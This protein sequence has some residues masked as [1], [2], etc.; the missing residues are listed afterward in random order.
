MAKNKA[1]ASAQKAYQKGKN[2]RAVKA[3]KPKKKKEKKIQEETRAVKSAKPKTP[4]TDVSSQYKEYKKSSFAPKTTVTKP[5]VSNSAQKAFTAGQ[6]ARE[7]QKKRG[8][9]NTSVPKT[10]GKISDSFKTSK[11]DLQKAYKKGSQTTT[12]G[13]KQKKTT[14]K[15]GKSKLE[16]VNALTRSE[17]S[18][19]ETASRYG[20]KMGNQLL[21]GGKRTGQKDIREKVG[22]KTAESA[23]KSKAATGVMQGMSKADIFSNSVGTYNKQAK[24]AIKKTKE[25]AAYNVGY[26]LGMAADMGMGGVASRGASAAELTGKGAAKLLGKEAAKQLPKKAA[27]EAAEEVAKVSGKQGAK[28]FAKNRAGEL[29]AET[30]TNVLD[31]AKMSLDENGKLDKKEFKKWLA[32]NTGLTAG[33]GG[34]MEGIGAAATKKLSNKTI[35]LLGK[36]QAGTISKDEAQQLAKNLDKLKNKSGNNALSGDIASKGIN[37]VNAMA[38][39]ARI[40]R[41]KAKSQARAPRVEAEFKQRKIDRQKRFEARNTEDKYYNQLA[42]ENPNGTFTDATKTN[43]PN[44]DVRPKG[45]KQ[46]PKARREVRNKVHTALTKNTVDAKAYSKAEKA[47]ID[48]TIDTISN[49]IHNGDLEG[50]R[51]LSKKLARKYGQV[52]EV[53]LSSNPELW[54]EVKNAQKHMRSITIHTP[55]GN[56]R[57]KDIEEH[58]IDGYDWKNL[59]IRKSTHGKNRSYGVDEIW[60]E[61]SENYPAVFSKE[62]TDNT[63]RLRRLAEVS[64]MK[65]KDTASGFRLG[66]DE[67]QANQDDVWQ[68]IYAAAEENAGKFEGGEA[69]SF[70]AI[71]EDEAKRLKNL[72]AVNKRLDDINAKKE[73]AT[74]EE[75][76]RL[77][78]EESVVK[79]AK[80]NLENPKTGGYAA[81]DE[82]MPM[83]KG[84]AS[85][86]QI[87]RIIKQSEG[88]LDGVYSA[89]K[90][91]DEDGVIRSETRG[92][93]GVARTWQQVREA[94]VDNF[95][96]LED[97]AKQLPDEA[98]NKML[99][100]INELRR[101]QKT[102]RA[103]VAE[104]GRA[105]YSKYG[106]TKRG[107]ETE[108]KREDFEWYCF[109]KHELDRKKAGNN[110][111]DLSRDEIYKQLKELENKYPK[112][113][114][115]GVVT[116]SQIA[117]FQKETTKYFD[118]LLEREVDA[119]ITSAE[120][121]ANFR[122]MY[123]NYVPTYKPQEFEQML[124]RNTKDEI[125]VGRGLKAATGGSHELVPL[126]NQMQ[127]KTNVVLKRTELNRTLNLLCQA[128]G[129]TL[130]ELDEAIPFF[131][132]MANEDKPKALLDTQVF[133]QAREGKHIA[134]MYH[135]GEK[136]EISI[137]P[138]VYDAIRRWSGED[139]K[140]LTLSRIVDNKVTRGVNTQFKKWITDYNIFFGLKNFKR[141]TATALYYTKDIK[142]F[143]KNFPKA[144]AVCTLPDKLLTK[145]MKMYKEAL[146]VYKE[147]GGIISQFIARDTATTTFFDT[148]GKFNP[149]KWAE[150]FNSTLETIPR[151][152]EFLSAIESNVAKQ[153]EKKIADMS[154]EELSEAFSA[155]LKDKNVIADS[156]YRA[157]D[158]TLNFDRSGWLGSMLNRG[159]VPFFNPAIQGLDKLGRKLITDNIK[160][161]AKMEI[162]A[163]DTIKSFLKMGAALTGMVALPTALW[164]SM[165]G[166]YI[167]G[168]V[169]GYEKQSD[170]NRYANYLLPVGDGKFI[171][172]PKARELA[173][174]QASLDYAFDNMKYGSG[175]KWERLFGEQKE[176]D[177]LSMANIAYE[178]IGPVS[179][180]KDNIL[181][182]VW[183]VYN[184]E[185]WY[186]GKIE[187]G[188]DLDLREQGRISEIWDEDTSG[189]AKYIGKKFNLSPKK[190]DNVMDSYLGVL[191]DM[192]IKQTSSRNSLKGESFGSG[193]KQ[194]LSSQVSTNFMIDSVFQNANAT[195][196]YNEVDRRNEKLKKLKEGTPEYTKV[197]AE[198]NK[199]KNAFAYTSSQYDELMAQ[200]YLDKNLTRAQ[201]NKYARL[202]KAQQNAMWGDRKSGKGVSSVD[203]MADAW[204]LK[205]KNGKRVLSTETIIN[206]CSYT[207]KSGNNTIKDAYDLYKKNGGKSSSKFMEV[208]LAAR[209]VNRSAGDSLSS[210]RYEVIAYANELNGIKNSDKVIKSYIE[211]DTTRQR[212]TENAKIYKEYGFTIKNY[213]TQRKTIVQGAFD[214]GYEYAGDIRDGE[215][216]M[217]LA[218]ARTKKG[219][220]Y[221]DGSYQANDFY[222]M[223]RMNGARCLDA[224]KNGN[225]KAKDIKDLCDK[226][227]LKQND[228]YKWDTDKVVNAINKE[229]PNASQEVK[230]AMFNVITGYTYKNPFGSIGDYSLDTDT[231]VY[232]SGGYGGWGRRRRRRRRGHWGRYGGGGR[233]S[234]FKPVVN[235]AG[236]K[237]KVSNTSRTNSSSKSNLDDAYRRKLKKLREETRQVK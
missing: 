45:V 217:L 194:I 111:T 1:L 80:Q 86:K 15:V 125:D 235:D 171:K 72:E 182:P 214:L 173:S 22:S 114:K 41:A 68:S 168:K 95:A 155:A 190:V 91:M 14:T 146:Q 197:F 141:D 180:F 188:R 11:K 124:K 57:L 118:D 67:I 52:D 69:R 26:G 48:N 134:V 54:E 85:E 208:T 148:A 223:N 213:R 13:T 74:P 119:G 157:K 162:A 84:T 185:T 196:Y 145:D 47:E 193:L 137:D 103:L 73:T 234:A 77:N 94:L 158:V 147:N 8:V 224:K 35:S 3:Q 60:D 79:E 149:L 76:S 206:S 12:L 50:A 43:T 5:K 229:H 25:S 33:V 198:Q 116:G 172:I 82:E 216:S 236:S 140:W 228:D 221:R 6:K 132:H 36:Q 100:Q 32:V 122:R 230:A 24:K 53:S 143:I 152:T 51:D 136:M 20:K 237:A 55:K 44:P 130:D 66:E 2:A 27:K 18:R 126:Y 38:K 127:V 98:R 121:A 30:P 183:R 112:A 212:L 63:E 210:P 71:A 39:E 138:E 139:R 28:R 163:G 64:A 115:D 222:I 83:I 108:L 167:N 154:A 218:N 105:I 151:M 59:H 61:L 174:I 92:K 81:L 7:A 99:A 153:S 128:S 186:G 19:V 200:I 123:P 9:T 204:N 232:C 117:D 113:D 203:P 202:I 207:S 165:F 233:G 107:L 150:N 219:A 164:D 90:N 58:L 199:D 21:K 195:D 187:S 192:G 231:G 166:D 184:N 88:D 34:A 131:K 129:T 104:K 189:V 31:A 62:I 177:L 225:Y 97:I 179:P 87:Q 106:L 42:K 109:L 135:N 46:T 16:S 78:A 227:K 17:M 4:S 205:D 56:G 191:Y 101:S 133:T 170:Y 37:D 93:Q 175:S 96:S 181:S 65:E 40:N 215:K 169:E 144:F 160:R 102:G 49:R 178:Q 209:D 120:E 29:V 220:K 176:R 159:V 156:M 10:S 70:D 89:P 142:G 110:F 226:Y 211:K 23:Y 75:L 201:K 161:G